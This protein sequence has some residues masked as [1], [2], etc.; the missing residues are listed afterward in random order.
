M[1]YAYLQVGAASPQL[2]DDRWVRSWNIEEQVVE[3]LRS[4]SEI[5]H[6]VGVRTLKPPLVNWI[7]APFFAAG[8]HSEFALKLPS[9]LAGLATIVLTMLVAR[10]LCEAGCGFVTIHA[11]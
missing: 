6:L 9:L 3:S 4:R 7:G 2:T 5:N 10:R 1:L 8:W 11:G